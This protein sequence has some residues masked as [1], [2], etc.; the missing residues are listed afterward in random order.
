MA[1]KH[2]ISNA[3]TSALS[4][5]SSGAGIGSLFGPQAAAIG[6]GIGATLG[7]LKGLL[8]DTELQE[9]A[10]QWARGEVDPQTQMRIKQMV[11]DRFASLR[12]TQG[13]RLARSGV[14][15]SSI[16]ERLM[17]ETDAG[18]RETLT[19]ALTDQSMAFRRMGL[20][21]KAQQQAQQG[22]VIGGS[23]DN[24]MGLISG[25][26]ADERYAQERADL[27]GFRSELLG[28]ME[29]GGTT[30]NPVEAKAA[31]AVGKLPSDLGRG[32][33]GTKL[34]S[35]WSDLNKKYDRNV[36]QRRTGGGSYW[37]RNANPGMSGSRQRGTW[38][39]N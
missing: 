33:A 15:D 9:L 21:L 13:G 4:W 2:R 1:W 10:D 36:S 28:L 31:A 20:N 29:G 32:K 38:N 35:T 26:K 19:N 17:A 25:F 37:N 22:E 34:T 27:Q 16:A 6:G 23:V 3:G 12:R 14:R 18:E 39:V 7:L 5:G 11:A 30:L 24:I 8:S